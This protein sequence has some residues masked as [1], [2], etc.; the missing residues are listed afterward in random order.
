M[1]CEGMLSDIL[2]TRREL[3]SVFLNDQLTLFLDVMI[4]WSGGSGCI[5][6]LV[7]SSRLNPSGRENSY[8]RIML[9]IRSQLNYEICVHNYWSISE[10]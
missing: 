10:N 7:M 5:V 8:D 4:S 1:C 9:Y 6:S 2:T 3:V